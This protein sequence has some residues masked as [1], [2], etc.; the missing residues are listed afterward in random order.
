MVSILNVGLG[1]AQ[2]S[3]P[4]PWSGRDIGSPAVAGSSSFNQGQFTVIA[5]GAD[6]WGQS[7]QFH[8]VYQQVSGDV[9]VI[10][11]VDS[12]TQVHSWSK[13]GVMIR[14]SLAAN[15]AHGYAL[16]SAGKGTAFQ[17]RASVG[18]RS[19]NTYGPAAKAPYWVR[20]VRV[21]TTVTA[22]ASADGTTWKTI[23]SATIALG[24]VAYVGLATTSHNASAA[25]T[26]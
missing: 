12:V 15:A 25:T 4:S 2:S 6:I 11:R 10:A 14:S 7:D 26:A 8:F 20:L 23:D 22:Y 1:L 24:T 16:V 17:N 9:D 13:M 5:G 19:N 3:V 21:G 18:A